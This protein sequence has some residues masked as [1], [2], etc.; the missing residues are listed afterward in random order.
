MPTIS[1]IVPVYKTEK[2]LPRCLDSILAQTFDDFEIIIVDDGSPDNARLVAERYASIDRRVKIVSQTNQGLGAARNTGLAHACG[3]FISF[4]DSDDYISPTMFELMLSAISE[5]SA[6]MAVCQA[7]NISFNHNGGI[8]ELGSFAIPCPNDC[9]TGEE[10]LHLQLNFIVP[11]LFN[12][13]CFKLT[14]RKVF[15]DSGILFPEQHRYA[16]DTPTSIGLFLFCD[17]IALV[18]KDLY[19]YV[20]NDDSLTSS[21]SIK[22][23]HDILLDLVDIENYISKSEKDIDLSNFFIGMLFPMQ[24]Q[25]EWSEDHSEQMQIEI[26]SAI[27]SIRRK[28]RPNFAIDGIPLAQKAKIAIAYSGKTPLVCAI[29]KHLKWIPLFRFMM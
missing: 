13:M 22:K 17:K 23:S 7:C 1:V 25:M 11:I 18:K 5:H 19:F 2:T 20:H 27:S 26:S 15:E 10:A 12:S 29:L 24:K 9:I 8:K 16:E 3:K 21:Y 14:K 4:V 6:E 28:Y